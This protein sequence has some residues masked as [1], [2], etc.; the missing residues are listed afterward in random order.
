VDSQYRTHLRDH[1]LAGGYSAAQP[2][3]QPACA[4]WVIEVMHRNIDGTVEMRG[5][6]HRLQA[7]FL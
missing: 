1:D 4:L 2:L 7:Q 6:R 3:D 5:A